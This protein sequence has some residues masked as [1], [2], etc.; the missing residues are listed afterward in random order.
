MYWSV[1]AAVD[2]FFVFA[3]TTLLEWSVLLVGWVS[4][5]QWIRWFICLQG[6]QVGLKQWYIA[7]KTLTMAAPIDCI[8]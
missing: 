3:C 4:R 5:G 8:I 1:V 6:L 2:L 7:T